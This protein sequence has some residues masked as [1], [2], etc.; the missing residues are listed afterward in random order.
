VGVFV[1]DHGGPDVVGE[2][3]FEAAHGFDEISDKKGCELSSVTVRRRCCGPGWRVFSR[4][5]PVGVDRR[6]PGTPVEG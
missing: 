5:A 3:A 2:A 4:A 1:G 6:A